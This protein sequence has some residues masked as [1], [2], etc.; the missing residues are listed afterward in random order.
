MQSSK[1]R[2][3]TGGYLNNNPKLIAVTCPQCLRT[4]YVKATAGEK[5][6]CN[7]GEAF[8]PEENDNI[9]HTKYQCDSCSKKFFLGVGS[10]VDVINC[11]NCKAPIDLTKPDKHGNRHKRFI[12]GGIKMIKNNYSHQATEIPRR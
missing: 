3:P 2:K 1:S 5:I 11:V 10:S 8:A 9:H 7:C 6:Q 12:P 4:L